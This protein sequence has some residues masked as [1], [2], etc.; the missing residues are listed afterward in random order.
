[1]MK[2][3]PTWMRHQYRAKLSKIRAIAHNCRKN[4]QIRGRSPVG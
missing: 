1:M 4:L 2:R 3:S